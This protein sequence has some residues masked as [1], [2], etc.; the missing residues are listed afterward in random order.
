MI[1]TIKRRE[2]EQ[3]KGLWGFWRGAGINVGCSFNT[4]HWGGDMRVKRWS[5]WGTWPCRYLVKSVPVQRFG[6]FEKSKEA[7]VAQAEWAW[8]RIR[9]DEVREVLA[10]ISPGLWGLN[11]APC[12]SIRLP[13]FPLALSLSQ[14]PRLQTSVRLWCLPSLCP[15]CHSLARSCSCVS[16]FCLFVLIPLSLI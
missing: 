1:S 10:I 6:I 4:P 9:G 7:S 13:I 16:L 2:R 12:S 14:P 3:G 5:W 15:Y 11:E 8:A